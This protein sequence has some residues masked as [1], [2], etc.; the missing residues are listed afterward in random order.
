MYGDALVLMSLDETE[1]IFTKDFE[2]HTD[3]DAI[4]TFMSEVIQK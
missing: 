3:V 4:G 2:N 1:E